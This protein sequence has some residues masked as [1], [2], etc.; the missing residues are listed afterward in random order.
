MFFT[1]VYISSSLVF[2]AALSIISVGTLSTPYWPPPLALSMFLLLVSEAALD[3]DSVI[4]EPGF[5]LKAVYYYT[6]MG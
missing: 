6:H 5:V 1:I 2:G 3:L 4:I